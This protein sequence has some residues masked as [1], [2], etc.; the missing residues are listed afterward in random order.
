MNHAS[1]SNVVS[2]FFF[3]Y[4]IEMKEEKKSVR[5]YGLCLFSHFIFVIVRLLVYFVL[6]ILVNCGANEMFYIHYFGLKQVKCASCAPHTC[7]CAYVSR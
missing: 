7:V 5:F 6:K 4:R 1:V 2:V 3:A